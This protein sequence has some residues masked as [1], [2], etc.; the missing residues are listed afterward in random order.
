MAEAGTRPSTL[1]VRQSPPI[2]K[3]TAHLTHPGRAFCVPAPS[4]QQDSDL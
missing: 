2:V 4:S 3:L 1:S